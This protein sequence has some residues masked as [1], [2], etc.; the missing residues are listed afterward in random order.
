MEASGGAS[1]NEGKQRLLPWIV[2][3]IEGGQIEGLHWLNDEKTLFQIPWTHKG[4]Q[5]WNEDSG[6]IFMVGQWE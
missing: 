1:S 5:E 3:Q 6:R 4:R 2:A